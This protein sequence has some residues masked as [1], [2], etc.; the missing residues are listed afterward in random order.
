MR[1]RAR[2]AVVHLVRHANGQAAFEAF[3]AAYENVPARLE[4]DLVLLCKGFPD[5]GALAPV[6]ERAAAH[7]PARIELRDDGFD[8]GAYAVAADTLEHERLCFLNSFS[9]PRVDGWLALLDAA[10]ADTHAAAAG[11]TGS[12]ASNH[13][14]GLYLAGLP[15]AYDGVLPSRAA[16]RAAA[17]EI[18]GTTPGRWAA[19]WVYNAAMT[20]R[21]APGMTRFPAVHLRTNALLVDRAV[22]CSLRIGRAATKWA[23]YHLESGRRSI[24]RQLL[25][26]GRSPLVVDRTGAARAP[27][28][29]HRANVF[30]QSRQEDLLVADNQTRSYADAPPHLR[31]FLSAQAWGARARPA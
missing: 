22:F 11:A 31:A 28:D 19:D 25:A 8:L 4:H 3:M 29:W 26:R 24:T 20:T 1:Q 7:R 18:N 2:T 30:W 15:T 5:A 6:I 12:W 13:E 23:T 21:Y 14:F 16:S 9:E 10:L 27:A 17:H